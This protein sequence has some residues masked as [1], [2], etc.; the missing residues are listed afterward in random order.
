MTNAVLEKIL[1]LL[2]PLVLA[3]VQGDTQAAR[4]A[5]R[6]MLDSYEPRTDRELR[7]AALSIAFGFGALDALSKAADPDL[8]P[9]QAIRLRGNANALHRSAEQAD[10]RLET[11]RRSPPDATADPAPLPA[12]VSTEDL[13]A[14]AKATM[15]APP[16]LT[17]QQRRAAE[18]QAEKQRRREQQAPHRAAA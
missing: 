6:S 11:L 16:P 3:A 12:S 18:R 1:T 9:N 10:K 7:L 4:D 5:A 8:T 2:A 13:L 15:N 14:F 17:R